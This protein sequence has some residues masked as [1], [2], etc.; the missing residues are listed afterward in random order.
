MTLAWPATPDPP[1]PGAPWARLDLATVDRPAP[2]AA[3]DLQAAARNAVRLTE[4]ADGTPIRLATKSLRSRELLVALLGTDGFTGLMAHSPAEAVWLART[5]TSDDIL[6][7][8]PTTARGP[9]TELCS[10]EELAARVTVTVDDPAQLDLIDVIA[11]PGRRP[12]V[13]VCLDLDAG[14]ALG[15]ARIGARR[16]ALR[17]R[18]EAV[19]AA[20]AIAERPGF[21]LVGALAYEAQIAGVPDRGGVTAAQRLTEVAVTGAK[22]VSVRELAARRRAVVTGLREVADLEFVNGGGTGSI[23]ST[24]ADPSVTEIGA[25][26]GVLLGHLFDRYR[27]FRAEPAC[28]FALDVDRVPTPDLVVVHGGGWAASGPSGPDRLPRPVHPPGLRPTRTEAVGEV[29]TPLR[30]PRDMAGR[31]RLGD[32]VWFRHAKSGEV[33]EHVN[34]FVVV[35]GDTVVTTIATYRGEG[36]VF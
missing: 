16:S 18:A 15:P 11:M 3:I 6:V 20:R 12:E 33:A 13:R 22:L 28:G 17:T 34:E 19:A 32:R 1:G 29:Q 7:G 14:L 2:L 23:E 26:S 35:D 5:G 31:I 25:G 36:Q 10:D 9:L 21:S 30:V 24:A 27:G 8:Y 4:R